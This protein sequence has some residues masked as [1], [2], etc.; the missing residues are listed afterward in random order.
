MENVQ[1]NTNL[2]VSKNKNMRQHIIA[3]EK[4]QNTLVIDQARTNNNLLIG[5][6]CKRKEIKNFV[7]SHTVCIFKVKL[8]QKP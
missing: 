5:Y 8:K 6:W 4:G 7:E 2:E 3:R 1:Q